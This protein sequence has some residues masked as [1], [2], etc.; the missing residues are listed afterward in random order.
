MGGFT[1]LGFDCVQRENEGEKG[2]GARRTSI[3]SMNSRLGWGGG[4]IGFSTF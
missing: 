1:A 4:W 2:G 3:C